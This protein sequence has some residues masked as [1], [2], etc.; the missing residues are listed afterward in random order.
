[1]GC[2]A[3]ECARALGFFTVWCH[4]VEH[5]GEWGGDPVR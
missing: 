3:P 2:R 4:L 5:S 1:M